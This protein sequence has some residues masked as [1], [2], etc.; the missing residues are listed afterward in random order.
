MSTLYGAGGLTGRHVPLPQNPIP[1]RPRPRRTGLDWNAHR[2]PAIDPDAIERLARQGIVT[3]TPVE[4]DGRTTRE[5]RK[6]KRPGRSRS[7]TMLKHAARGENHGM[8]RE[9]DT[10]KLAA[11]YEAGAT[12][13]QLA[14]EHHAA[15][16]TIRDRLAAHGVTIRPPVARPRVPLETL[17][18]LRAQGLSWRQVGEQAG[19]S[20][21]VARKRVQR[22][23]QTQR[24]TTQKLSPAQ[25]AQDTHAGLSGAQIA[26]KHGVRVST[27]YDVRMRA[28]REGL[29]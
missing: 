11:A 21:D 9:L 4:Q 25:V 13:A 27:V 6:T 26:Q 7:D 12:L 14:K 3:V 19:I 29:L 15:A 18:Q 23:Q 2:G 16:G 8:W 20:G 10:A 17:Q 28:R 24:K 22:P 5:V 1:H